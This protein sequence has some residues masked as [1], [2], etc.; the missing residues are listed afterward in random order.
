MLRSIAPSPILMCSF[1]RR[2]E[3]MRDCFCFLM[4]A[5][6]IRISLDCLHGRACTWVVS[7]GLRAVLGALGCGRMLVLM[8]SLLLEGL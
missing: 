4:V 3:S 2:T 5:G 7:M 8:F 6:G 1:P